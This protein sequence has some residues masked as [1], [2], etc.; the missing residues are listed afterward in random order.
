[1][2]SV[3]ETR[4]GQGRKERG[5]DLW[6]KDKPL[7][8]NQLYLLDAVGGGG[9]IAYYKSSSDSYDWNTAMHNRSSIMAV[10]VGCGAIALAGVG[11]SALVVQKSVTDAALL[12]FPQIIDLGEV[13]RATTVSVPVVV[14]NGD[15]SRVANIARIETSCGCMI[16][17]A[18]SFGLAPGKEHT[19]VVEVTT[20]DNAGRSTNSVTLHAADGSLA[21]FRI[22]K[23]AVDPFPQTG[24]P[25]PERALRLPLRESYKGRIESLT[26]YADAS[27]DPL[28][29]RLDEH[30]QE[31]VIDPA[32]T[33]AMVE[34]VF[35]LSDSPGALLAQT[36]RIEP[37]PSRG[38]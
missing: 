24:T 32:P 20:T 2:I 12:D 1:M 28:P 21:V 23:T 9:G 18:Q 29:A 17:A 6:G 25:G 4:R 34:I 37:P 30:A 33:G 31:L 36:V 8:K 14:R 35:R 10:V 15:Q 13:P 7:G 11:G 3:Q 19:L 5:N 22:Q 27:D 38:P 26:A 16:P